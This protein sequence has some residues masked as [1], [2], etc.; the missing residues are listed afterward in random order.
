[1]RMRKPTVQ[2]YAGAR[3]LIVEDNP[4]RLVWFSHRLT[5]CDVLHTKDPDRAIELLE[6]YGYVGYHCIFLDHDLGGDFQP[7]YTTDVAKAIRDHTGMIF[8]KN[9]VIHSLNP[10]GAANLQTILPPAIRLS[11]GSFEI[12][13]LP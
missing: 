4:D 5:G 6:L 7:P 13:V 3:V 11:F 12:E 2:V 9:I 8:Q 1:M 10:A